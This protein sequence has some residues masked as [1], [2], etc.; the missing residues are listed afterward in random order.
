MA[1]LS[2][3]QRAK[4]RLLSRNFPYYAKNVLKIKDKSGTLVPLELNQAQRYLHNKL[5]KQLN[6]TGKV[7]ALIPKARQM[8]S[9]TYIGGRFFHKT[10]LSD[11]GKSAF[12][13]SH[14]GETTKKLFDMVKRYYDY[15]PPPMLPKIKQSNVKELI[16]QEYNSQ[17]YVGT[18]GN[19]DI[20]RGGTVQFFHGSEVAFWKNT[21]GIMTGVLQSVPDL[22]GTEIILESTGNGLGNMFHEICVDAARGENG[23]QVIFIPWF[24]MDEYELDVARYQPD[25]D[26]IELIQLYLNDLPEEKQMRKLA[27]RARKIKEFKSEWKFR[28]EYPATFLECFQV[29]GD[30]LIRSAHIVAARQCKVTDKQS[31]LI[32]GVDP[33][34]SGDRTAIVFRRGR[35]IPHFYTFHDM[36]EM[37]LV[38]IVANLIDQHDVK[39]CNMDVAQGWGTIDR[40]HERGYKMVNGV[41]FG[42]RAIEDDIYRNKRAEMWCSMAQ[43]MEKEDVNIPDSDDFHADLIAVPDIKYTSD[44]TKKLESKEKI[45]Q[46]FGKSPDIGDA[47]ALTF[48]FPYVKEHSKTNTI[49]KF[50][51]A[52][53]VKWRKARHG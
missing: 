13:L 1:Q 48:A 8:G 51:N 46:E 39:M 24:W 53:Q 14:E 29:S 43:W 49:T 2:A 31:P 17:Y 36:D 12:I 50:N 19:A 10:T 47:A 35:E 6:D 45:K 32:M 15:A 25:S 16:F 20:G 23:Y 40:L 33:A 26:E 5:E 9:S 7:R 44:G 30:S 21:D 22:P 38:G 3:E 42:E 4:V 37:R 41:H 27:W 28:Q 52:N 18:A 11:R 34:R